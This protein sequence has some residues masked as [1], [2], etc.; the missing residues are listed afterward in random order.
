MHR[1][2]LLLAIFLNTV[3]FSIAGN[4]PIEDD[5]KNI[6]SSHPRIFINSFNIG[7]YREKV[8]W[9]LS[10]PF[11]RLMKSKQTKVPQR[12]TRLKDYIYKNAYLYQITGDKK[13]A[14]HVIEAMEQLPKSLQAYGSNEDSSFAHALEAWSIGFDWC[15]D[16]IVASG[17]KDQFVTWINNYFLKVRDNLSTLPDFHNYASQDEFAILAAGLATYGDNPQAPHYISLAKDIVER[18]EKRGGI[19]YNAAE[20]IKFVDGTCNWEGVTYGRQQLFNYFKY[21]EAWRTAT[22]NTINPWQGVFAKLENAGYYIIYSLR[23]DDKFENLADI[24]YPRISYYDIN[25]LAA[26]ESRFKNGYFTAF[27]NKYYRWSSGKLIT[28][29]WLGRFDSS[30][31]YYLLWYDPKIKEKDLEELPKTRKFGDVIIMRTGFKKTDTMLSLKSGIHWGFHSQ[32]DHGSFTIYKDVPLAIDSGYYDSWGSGKEHNWSYWKR[33]I[34]HNSLLIYD[35][36]EKRV[37]YPRNNICSNDG[38]QRMA[39]ITFSPPHIKTGSTNKPVSIQHLNKHLEEFLMGTF[40]AYEFTSSYDYIKTDI[41]KAYNNVYSGKGTN[42][43]RKVDLVQREFVYLKPDIVVVFDKVYAAKDSL[44]KKWL[45]HS[46]SYYDKSAQPVLNGREK[47]LKGTVDQGITESTD[48]DLATITRGR[49]RLF[50]KTLLP[51]NHVT[52]KIGG[53]G[54]EFWV[55]DKNVPISSKIIPLE[56]QSED[57]GAWRIEIQPKEK[58]KNDFFLHLISISDSDVSSMPDATTIQTNSKNMIGIRF[59]SKSDNFHYIVMFNSTKENIKNADLDIDGEGKIK[60]LL[61]GLQPSSK[62]DIL[63]NNQFLENGTSSAEGTLYFDLDLS[64]NK[65]LFSIRLK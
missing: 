3:G 14:E 16:Q 57:P 25:N 41:T 43:P 64:G 23:P 24:S 21:A 32:L 47:V 52:R 44:I 51:K 42:Q 58:Q 61:S 6:L 22:N 48:T 31:V 34:A 38:G 53:Q 4:I 37:T 40:S 65:N 30:L 20:S 9:L 17:K 54:Y 7:E 62:Y 39:F 18:G 2:I 27:I 59:I 63:R 26:L 12:L 60:A 56:R 33:T 13:W 46:G 55:D 50:I 45:L 19:I 28:D 36:T 11:E 15:Y 29:I 8:Q 49:G 1:L 10:E 35:A 5:G